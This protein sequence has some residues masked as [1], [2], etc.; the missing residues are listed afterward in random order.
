V[1]PRAPRWLSP[2]GRQFWR[3]VVPELV[4]SGVLH[5][6]LDF[7]LLE[8]TAE[9]Y[10]L[11]RRAVAQHLTAEDPA[12]REQLR[13]IANVEAGAWLRCAAEFGLTPRSRQQ[14]RGAMEQGQDPTAQFVELLRAAGGG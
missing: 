12:E 11:W 14:L 10:G 8:V 13:R 3:A 9:S 2:E 7:P 6:V 5:P 1:T 4:R